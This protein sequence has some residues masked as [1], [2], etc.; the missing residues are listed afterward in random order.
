VQDFEF[1]IRTLQAGTGLVTSGFPNPPLAAANA[2]LSADLDALAAYV[3]SLQVKNSPFRNAD[4]SLSVAAV[5]GTLI[6]ERSDTG[7]SDC[8]GAPLFTDSSL[9]AA[10]FIVHDVG[11]GGGPDENMGPEFDT[12]SLR[13]IRDTAPYLHD[14][15]ANTLRD[16]LVARNPN[17]QHG[18]TSQLS[19]GELDALVAYLQSL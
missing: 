10:P 4:G 1:T 7:C 8:H 16:L 18:Q 13:G 3:E 14:G 9:T 6:F 17:D 15:S 19:S 5:A 2:G 12:P 11:T